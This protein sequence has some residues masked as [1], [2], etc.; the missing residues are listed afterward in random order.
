MSIFLPV[1]KF[2]MNKEI[3]KP[4]FIIGCGRSGTTILGK[5]LSYHNSIIYLNEPRDI[6]FSCYPETDIWTD[7]AEE[8]NGKL[9]MT[10][11]DVS[12]RKSKKLK[13][14]LYKKTQET[15]K[16]ILVEKL[17]VNSFRL[18]FLAHIF[19]DARFIYILRSGIDVALSIE[20]L[21]NNGHWFASHQYKWSLLYEYAESMQETS[22]IAKYCNT[23]YEKGLL[24]WR[25]SLESFLSFKEKKKESVM[26]CEVR[27]EDF[28]RNPIHIMDNIFYFLGLDKDSSVDLF[29]KNNIKSCAVKSADKN[30]SDKERM[31]VG[32]KNLIFL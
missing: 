21:S 8:K 15:N 28:S 27:Y 26:V 29:I 17:P 31:I 14:L 5:T 9:I 3:K 6:W 32:D 16:S 24:E 30:L 19:P 7:K 12:E 4:V 23:Y 22:G 18:Y 11:D 2:F 10:E 1:K 13:F 25:L 20:N